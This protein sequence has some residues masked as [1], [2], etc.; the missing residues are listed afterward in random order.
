MLETPPKNS[1][2]F[3]KS[4]AIEEMVKSIPFVARLRRFLTRLGITSSFLIFVPIVVV[5]IWMRYFGLPVQVKHYVQK[6][7]EQQ[8]LEV[9]FERLLLDPSGGLL[10]DRLTVYR[11]GG[12]EQVWIQ[13]D[14]VRIGIAWFSWWRGE[15]LIQSASIRNAS[16][17]L[18][19][20][21][22]ESIALEETQA[23]VVFKNKKI[24]V[25]DARARVINFQLQLKGTIELNGR[26]PAR[27]A[28]EADIAY[29]ENLWR[30]FRTYA[31]EFQGDKPILVALD[32]KTPTLHP[33]KSEATLY[34][35]T[36]LCRWRGVQIQEI[37]LLA[38]LEQSRLILEDIHLQLARGEW[39]AKGDWYLD[40]KRSTM[41][42]QSTLDISAFADAFPGRVGDALRKLS[43][44]DP[45][46]C[47]G[48]FRTFFDPNFVFD[49]QVVLKREICGR[50]FN[51]N[52][53][54]RHLIHG[55]LA[56]DFPIFRN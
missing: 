47:S 28:T 30:S 20:G 32:F 1:R 10:A 18:P 40:E 42:F 35:N 12:K 2:S 31:A 8:G 29:R 6:E 13:V 3:V 52:L 9:D 41:E 34:I 50:R 48:R 54:V 23:D 17:Q 39:I 44:D 25:I 22:H 37:G 38:R 49:L 43:F 56:I 16:I 15:P 46:R 27:P 21:P 33:E 55:N 26:A 36:K 45:A 19:L 11:G 7:L 4:E 53:F 24:E 51:I 14:R 5:F